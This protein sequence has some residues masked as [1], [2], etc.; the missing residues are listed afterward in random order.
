M[1]MVIFSRCCSLN[2]VFNISTGNEGESVLRSCTAF[3]L[4]DGGFLSW[5][6]RP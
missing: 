1:V 4:Y 3:L 5:L 6:F 2:P